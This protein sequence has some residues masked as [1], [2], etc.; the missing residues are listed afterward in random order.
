MAV[1]YSA[2]FFYVNLVEQHRDFDV[3]EL[4]FILGLAVRGLISF[5]YQSFI[6]LAVKQIRPPMLTSLQHCQNILN[7][8]MQ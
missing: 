2:C 3:V 5:L 1:S 6:D 4:S 8:F 7:H